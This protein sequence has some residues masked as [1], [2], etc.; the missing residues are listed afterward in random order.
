MDL[1]DYSDD[2]GS[3]EEEM[4]HVKPSARSVMLRDRQ[5]KR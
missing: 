5:R 2:Y 4:R 3:S 1:S